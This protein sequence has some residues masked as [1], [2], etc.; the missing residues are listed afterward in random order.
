MAKNDISLAMT[1]LLTKNTDP[2]IQVIDE[3]ILEG[4]YQ[5]LAIESIYLLSQVEFD[6]SLTPHILKEKKTSFRASIVF[7]Y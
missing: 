1:A 4:F 5:F 3:E 2:T 7:G 6:K